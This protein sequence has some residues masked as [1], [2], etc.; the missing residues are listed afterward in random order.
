VFLLR[1][2]LAGDVSSA[3]ARNATAAA[4]GCSGYGMVGAAPVAAALY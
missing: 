2:I 4:A 3:N 1:S